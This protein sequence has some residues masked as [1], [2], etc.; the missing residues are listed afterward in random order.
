MSSGTIEVSVSEPDELRRLGAWLRDEEPLRGRV[1]F[2]VRSPLPGQM[3]G[4]LESVVVIATSSTAPALCTALFG[5]LK[6]RRDAA[7]V[8]LKITNAAGKEL[9]LRCGSA[10]DATELL[11]SMRDFLGE[12]A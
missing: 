7:K 2:S 11:E 12:G 6:H 3:G 4:V 1:K 9:T 5:W 10:D 8:D